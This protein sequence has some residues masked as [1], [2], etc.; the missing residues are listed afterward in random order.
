MMAGKTARL[1]RPS[2]RWRLVTSELHV[3][4]CGK[5]GICQIGGEWWA[6]K[7]EP[8]G[9]LGKGPV[10]SIGEA[11]AIIEAHRWGF[12]DPPTVV[13]AKP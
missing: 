11:Q 2:P 8:L 12:V 9:Q 3:S 1:T 5:Y 10:R 7:R 13:M 6:F 4:T